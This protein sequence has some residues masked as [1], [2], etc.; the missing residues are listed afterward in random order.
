MAKDALQQSPPTP[1]AAS[2]PKSPRSPCSPSKTAELWDGYERLAVEKAKERDELMHE[3]HERNDCSTSRTSFDFRFKRAQSTI[4]ST[5]TSGCKFCGRPIIY[6]SSMCEGCFKRTVVSPGNEEVTTPLGAAED[7]MAVSSLCKIPSREEII[8]PTYASPKR[9]SFCPLPAHLTDASTRS[10]ST[11]PGSV[12]RRKKSPS[13][14]TQPSLQLQI[15]PST[16]TSRSQANSAP[17]TPTSPPGTAHSLNSTRRSSLANVTM[18]PKSR[19]PHARNDSGTPSEFSTLYQTVS[20]TTTPPASLRRFGY[21]L[22][23]TTSAW[24]DWDSDEE[25]EQ[26]EEEERPGLSSWMGRRKIRSRNGGGA[27][28][29]GGGAAGKTSMDQYDSSGEEA[30]EKMTMAR[31]SRDDRV[32]QSR[33]ESVGGTSVRVERLVEPSRDSKVK[34]PSGF[35]RAL[36]CGCGTAE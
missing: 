26:A 5:I 27:A 31:K 12:G 36:S 15:M 13:E 10:S 32:E 3:T 25:E 34:K 35:V 30:R 16:S 21:P 8:T 33:V 11:Q 28:G 1:G 14:P 23:N 24:D 6:A 2:P 18:L 17:M 4:P 7:N 9:A 19:Y 22:Q 20:T 29:G